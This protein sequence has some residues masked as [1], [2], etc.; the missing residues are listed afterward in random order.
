MKGFAMKQRVGL[1]LLF[2]LDPDPVD[3]GFLAYFVYGRETKR[4]CRKVQMMV[5]KLRNLGWNIK[6]RTYQIID[7]SQYKTLLKLERLGESVPGSISLTPGNISQFTKN[8]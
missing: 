5:S 7:N 1:K 8:K 3:S 2:N 6:P 4:N